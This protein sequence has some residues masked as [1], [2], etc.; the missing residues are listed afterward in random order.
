MTKV[1]LDIVTHDVAG[2]QLSYTG[3]ATAAPV[4]SAGLWSVPLDATSAN[5]SVHVSD[6]TN[7]PVTSP[8][9][10]VKI[11]KKVV[12]SPGGNGVDSRRRVSDGKQ[13]PGCTGQRTAGAHG[14][15]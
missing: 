15:H 4:D 6:G 14:L 11:I 9:S 3:E 2:D 5:V 12:I 7:S 8:K 10:N 13:R 1:T